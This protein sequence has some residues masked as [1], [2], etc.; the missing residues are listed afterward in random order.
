MSVPGDGAIPLTNPELVK[1][2]GKAVI[3]E[4]YDALGNSIP[5]PDTNRVWASLAQGKLSADAQASVDAANA[6]WAKSY[7][8][9]SGAAQAAVEAGQSAIQAKANA[10]VK[11]ASQQ[12]TQII[13]VGERKIASNA[14]PILGTLDAVTAGVQSLTAFDD[15]QIVALTTS[16]PWSLE[17]LQAQRIGQTNAAIKTLTDAAIAAPTS[18]VKGISDSLGHL[19]SGLIESFRAILAK[20]ESLILDPLAM[21]LTAIL[22]AIKEV[23]KEAA[24]AIWDSLLEEAV[25]AAG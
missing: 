11:Q 15:A 7:K 18:I 10:E 5:N 6:A 23:P 9:G 19:G 17:F 22:R 25:N 20:I 21:L 4:F 12:V 2:P 3:S 1:S 14:K 13:S 16:I 24:A 8:A